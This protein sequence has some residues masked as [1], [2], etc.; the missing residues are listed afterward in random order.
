MRN[1]ILFVATIRPVPPSSS[2]ASSYLLGLDSDELAKSTLRT[3]A[4]HAQARVE[5][6]RPAAEMY[7]LSAC[8]TLSRRLPVSNGVRP[9]LSFVASMRLVV[10][11]GREPNGES[12]PRRGGLA[13]PGEPGRVWQALASLGTEVPTIQYRARRVRGSRGCTGGEAVEAQKGLVVQGG[14]DPLEIEANQTA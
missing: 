9:V 4:A 6:R 1:T 10:T 12:F 8:R 7:I 14:F 2:M 5:A 3:V 11:S 13:G